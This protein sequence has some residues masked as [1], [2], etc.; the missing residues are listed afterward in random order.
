MCSDSRRHFLLQT[1]L[2]L[3]VARGSLALPAD[4][5]PAAR[6]D[7]A[8]PPRVAILVFPGVQIIDFAAPYEVFGEAGYDVFTVGATRE[9]LNTNMHLTITPR[10]SFADAPRPDVLLVPG[11]NINGAL[12]Q[13]QLLDWL[14][15]RSAESRQTVSVCN[16]A[17]FLAASHLLDGLEA[18]TYYGLIDQLRAQ[19]PNIRVVSDR[20]F[21]DNGKVVATA[22]LSS[23]IDGALHIVSKLSGRAAA[24]MVALNMEYNWRE[25]S[26]YARA[27]FADRHL[28]RIFGDRLQ[29]NVPSARVEVENTSGD[30][31]SW[32]ARWFVHGEV[33]TAAV[34]QAIS[35][36][37]ASQSTWRLVDGKSA[38]RRR[39]TFSDENRR[40]WD[41]RLDTSKAGSNGDVRATLT[42]HTS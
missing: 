16:G 19:Y 13:P 5:P 27:D 17:F 36:I 21:V 8:A 31:K 15:A 29:L 25:D 9:P 32:E 2:L 11:G 38:S 39:W 35:G 18:T 3:G 22:G 41:A 7:A 1:A 33:G 37:I 34:A 12:G 20:R 24:Q 4:T 10:Y 42:L 30:S 28:R 26:G 6:A 23:G 14:R 40:S